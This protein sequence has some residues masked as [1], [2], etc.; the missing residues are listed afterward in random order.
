MWEKKKQ[1]CPVAFDSKCDNFLRIISS[2]AWRYMPLVPVT[3]EAEA[4]ESLRPG[5]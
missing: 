2:Q 4:G 1:P 3:Q 5:V